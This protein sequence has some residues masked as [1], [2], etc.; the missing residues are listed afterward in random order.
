[1]PINFKHDP[2]RQCVFANYSGKISAAELTREWK[3]YLESADWMPG[4]SVINDLGDSD[5]SGVSSGELIDHV[6]FLESFVNS[7]NADIKAGRVAIVS[8]TELQFGMARM[9]EGLGIETAGEIKAFRNMDRAL[10]WA[11]EQR[12]RFGT[13]S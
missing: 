4:I 11:E 5:I 1:M 10:T 12:E 2:G 9:F 7:R 6:E 13:P 8:S 3:D